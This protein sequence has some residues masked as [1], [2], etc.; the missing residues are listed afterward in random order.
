V[1]GGRRK[2]NQPKEI[3]MASEG[4]LPEWFAKKK[5]IKRKGPER[6]RSR[7]RN[8]QKIRRHAPWL[9]KRAQGKSN[10]PAWAGWVLVSKRESRWRRGGSDQKKGSG[11]ETRAR[12]EETQL[13]EPKNQPKQKGLTL[14]G[15]AHQKAQISRKTKKN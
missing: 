4:G 13:C 9:R 3:V 15:K 10:N 6:N 2:T 11:K 5:Q 12:G 7:L 8:G 14:G 1:W